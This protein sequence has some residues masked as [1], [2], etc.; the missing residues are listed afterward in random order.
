MKN[1]LV[2]EKTFTMLATADAA[3]YE[4]QAGAGG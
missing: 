4:S 1:M 3:D 2:G